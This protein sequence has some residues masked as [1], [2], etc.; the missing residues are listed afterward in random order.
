MRNARIIVRPDRGC[1]VSCL[2]HMCGVWSTGEPERRSP[3]YLLGTR[4][5]VAL[6]F[7]FFCCLTLSIV[8]SVSVS[9]HLFLFVSGTALGQSYW[10]FFSSPSFIVL[11]AGSVAD[12]GW[13]PVLGSFSGV[14]APD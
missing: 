1:P 13:R 2:S 6:F 14:D 8:T 4:K 9:P 12:A 3:W 11:V 7:F 10:F 5:V